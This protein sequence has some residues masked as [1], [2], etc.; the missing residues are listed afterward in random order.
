MSD[1]IQKLKDAF[2][3]RVA[4]QQPLPEDG[5]NGALRD[6]FTKSPEA[7]RALRNIMLEAEQRSSQ[8]VGQD[9]TTMQGVSQAQKT[10]GQVHG[11]F[12]AVDII[13]DLMY[14]DNKEKSNVPAQ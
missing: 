10:Q 1:E 3:T 5:K 9:L 8:L 6:L 12:R 14:N 11:L 7:Q 13:I 2:Y 4:S